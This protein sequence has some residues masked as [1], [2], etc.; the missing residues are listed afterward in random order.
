[1]LLI[2]EC[3]QSYAV[4]LIKRIVVHSTKVEWLLS[5]LLFLVLSRCVRLEFQL[6]FGRNK[7]HSCSSN[8]K[9]A[10]VLPPHTHAEKQTLPILLSKNPTSHLSRRP[11]NLRT[12]INGKTFAWVHSWVLN[13]RNLHS[14][15]SHINHKYRQVASENACT[16][17]KLN[18]A[19]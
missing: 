12:W 10:Q 1:M 9:R 13:K 6:T 8:A 19:H 18:C 5:L 11:S 3:N 15:C 7:E 16:N 17:Y 2:C 4:T 14:K